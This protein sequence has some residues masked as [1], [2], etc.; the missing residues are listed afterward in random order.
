MTPAVD[1]EGRWHPQEVSSEQL[2][3]GYVR[4]SASPLC[5]Q[6]DRTSFPEN[7][8]LVD[9]RKISSEDGRDEDHGVP[10]CEECS[11]GLRLCKG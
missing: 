1:V 2:S 8:S 10:Y 6:A 3:Y 11:V 9:V 5:S 7:D 4:P